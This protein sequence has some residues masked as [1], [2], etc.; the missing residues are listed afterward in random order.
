MEQLKYQVGKKSNMSEKLKGEK[1]TLDSLLQK[2][3]ER[4]VEYGRRR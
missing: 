2:Q 4:T 1:E 3:R